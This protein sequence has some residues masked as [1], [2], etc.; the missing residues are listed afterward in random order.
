[1]LRS[2]G[3]PG[4]AP[5][6]RSIV[7][8]TMHQEND[9][10]RDAWE[11]SHDLVYHTES[12]LSRI[13]SLFPHQDRGFSASA[14]RDPTSLRCRTSQ[15][16]Q[17]TILMALLGPVAHSSLTTRFLQCKGRPSR[18]V[19]SLD[20]SRTCPIARAWGGSSKEWIKRACRLN[21]PQRG[22]T[23]SSTALSH[24]TRHVRTE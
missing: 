9:D 20:M 5:M 3:S 17:P 4:S 24:C 12:P 7:A 11:R 10:G 15:S 19:T 23:I 13:C 8:P 18:E 14:I 2:L 16:T 22:C 1:M 6:T 21:N